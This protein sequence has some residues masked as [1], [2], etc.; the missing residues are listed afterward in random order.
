MTSSA[1]LGRYFAI[2][3]CR[4]SQHRRV[5]DRAAWER[6]Y[7]VVRHDPGLSASALFAFVGIYV[8]PDNF[9]EIAAVSR[10][11]GEHRSPIAGRN[12]GSPRDGRDLVRD[13]DLGRSR[14]GLCCR[15]TST[16]VVLG[17]FVIPFMFAIKQDGA[18]RARRCCSPR[19]AEEKKANRI[20]QRFNRALNTMSHGLVM[21][22]PNGRVVVA[23]AEAAHLM[24]LQVA[25]RAAWRDP[26]TRC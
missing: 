7:I 4:P 1:S 24:S 14:S 25:R 16:T 8:A 5:R 20:A 17:L 11:A 2:R 13:R 26:S 21:L 10:D 15:A 12:F 18:P 22:G 19:S 6:Y 3:R 23:N 9:A